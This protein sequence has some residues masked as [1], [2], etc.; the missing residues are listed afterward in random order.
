MNFLIVDDE[1]NVLATT[2]ITVD[3]A[4]HNAFTAQTI[5]QADRI[6]GEEDIH[7]ILL[8]R[9][10]G[11]D[12][13]IE[14][15][16]QLF[17]RGV[18]VPI[19]IFTAH[20]SV[21]SVVEAMQ[22]GAYNYIQKPFVPEQIRHTLK[23]LEDKIGSSKQIEALESEA[24][25]Q[26]PGSVLESKEPRV[27][28][29]FRMAFKA[30]KSEASMLLMGDSGTGKSILARQIHKASDRSTRPFVEISCP[31]LS[32]EL[33]ESE[34]FGHV[35][36]AFTG[37][38]NDTW[39]KVQA[40]EGGTIFLD[41]IGELPLVIQPKLLRLLQEWEYERVGEAKSR[42]ADV[43]MITATNRDLEK[44]VR[45]G[46]FRED[47]FYRLTVISIT[48]P[49]LAERPADME[50]LAQH[51]LRFFADSLKRPD[52]EFSPEAL[53][54]IKS[55]GW[56]GNLR[57]LR[58][59]IERAGILCEGNVIDASDLS[60][61]HGKHPARLLPGQQVSLQAIEEA[62]IRNVVENTDN[63]EHAAEIL[64][65]DTATLYRKRK[66]MHLT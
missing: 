52:L 22:K 17:E 12:D 34:L 48:M 40:A 47:L 64:G 39:G 19:I 42:K 33:L 11:K 7:A 63:F 9:M 13:G 10:L 56:P 14:Y 1:K 55:Y 66:K 4:G 44:E 36:G 50:S 27:Q 59:V 35:K 51:F 32:G 28:D 57:E 31:S 26:N 49:P 18:K 24:S 45:E 41:E 20:S 58:N 5:R 61:D 21:E 2:A 46:R 62:H 15:M 43:R 23:N 38:V 30:A 65:I 60:I 29:A 37:A 8:D 53:A 25:S 54:A 16:E 3:T 6:L